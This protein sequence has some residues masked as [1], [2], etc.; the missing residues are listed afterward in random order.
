MLPPFPHGGVKHERITAH[1]TAMQR[2]KSLRAFEE[3]PEV[4]V[5]VLNMKMAGV[6]INL[7]T[8]NH[9]FLIDPPHNFSLEKQAIGRC[10]RLG[11]GREVY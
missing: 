1:R 11:Q 3:D 10:H 9:V 4:R 8:A 7:Q 2:Q 6:G 5:L